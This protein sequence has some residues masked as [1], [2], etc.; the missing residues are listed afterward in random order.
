MK[1]GGNQLNVFQTDISLTAFNAADVAPVE[2]DSVREIFLAPTAFF[3]ELAN[4]I[5][6]ESFDATVGHSGGIV[7]LDDNASTDLKSRKVSRTAEWS[8]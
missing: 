6:E 4:A 2:P 1:C 7:F 3:A 8:R 5:A